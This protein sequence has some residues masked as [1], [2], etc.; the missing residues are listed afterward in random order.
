LRKIKTEKR[1]AKIVETVKK[2]QPSLHVIIE[3]IH[4]K[5]NVSAIFRSCDAVGVPKISMIYT[6]EKY[7]KR[8]SKWSS[9][10]ASKWVEKQGYFEAEKCFDELKEQGFKI[11]AGTLSENSVSLY[12]LD[13]TGKTALV[14]GNEHRGISPEIAKLADGLFYIPM[15]GMV[16]SLNVASAA[17]VTLYEAQRQ[18]LIKGMY[19][20]CEY[21]E[22]E[23]NNLIDKWCNK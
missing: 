6:K 5:H 15:Q 7:P 4:D 14:F 20:K 13:L 3:N 9:A 16:Q 10:S 8:I 2:R 11:Y 17:A 22:D 1:L 23:M 12:N 18:R 19:E 21:S